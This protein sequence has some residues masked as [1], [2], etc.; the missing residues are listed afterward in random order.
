MPGGAMKL[1]QLAMG[2]H[3]PL[4]ELHRPRVCEGAPA[5]SAFGQ[6]RRVLRS[7]RVT[8]CRPRS[9]WPPHSPRRGATSAGR[10]RTRRWG[11][12]S[13]ATARSS[14]RAT[15]GRRA[16]TTPMSRRSPPR[17]AARPARP[18]L[19]PSSPVPTTAAPRGSTPSTGCRRRPS[20]A[21]NHAMRR[22]GRGRSRHS[23]SC[24]RGEQPGEACLALR[25]CGEQLAGP[26]AGA[27]A[28]DSGV[29][30]DERDAG[31][32]PSV[33]DSGAACCAV[34]SSAARARAS[35]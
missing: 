8:A 22:Q 6:S 29:L 12:S 33:T 26:V 3:Q 32:R 1:A 23:P 35:R 20:P 7:W 30:R 14:A 25:G 31:G 2:F 27:G 15:P 4:G 28:G 13:C 11:R 21:P 18:C 24:E 17:V 5:A 34:S 19:S 10:R 16:A 9:R